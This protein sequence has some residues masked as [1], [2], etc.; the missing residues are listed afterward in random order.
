MMSVRPRTFSYRAREARTTELIALDLDYPGDSGL[1]LL[2]RR[3]RSGGRDIRDSAVL[4]SGG[5]GALRDFAQLEQL[6]QAL[7]GMVAASRKA[8]D[9]GAAPRAV[10]VGQSGKNVG[11]RLYFA[12]GISG[13]SQH[14]AGL[15]NAECIIA[16]NTD[17]Q[18]PICSMADV[19]VEGDSRSFVAGLLARI[20]AYR[21]DN[22]GG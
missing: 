15:K 18:A 20:D 5:G 10:Q 1:R 8:V 16:V 19:V 14:A 3:D 2:D 22:Q 11:P 12:L 13:S 4:V 9:H 17:R 6:A 21:K 7:R